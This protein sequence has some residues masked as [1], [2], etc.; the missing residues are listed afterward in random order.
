M[1]DE[2]VKKRRLL[3]LFIMEKWQKKDKYFILSKKWQKID[4]ELTNIER[5][6]YYK[7]K[8]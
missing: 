6:L 4:R 5:Y 2:A 1:N 7:S 3:L 8:I